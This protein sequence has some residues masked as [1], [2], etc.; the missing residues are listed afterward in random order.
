MFA[1]KIHEEAHKAFEKGDYSEAILGYSKALI[2][3]P[4]NSIVLS[5]RAIA[6]LHT[7]QKEKCIADFDLAVELQPKY[8]FR[9]A[10][11]AYAKKHFNDIDGAIE[12]YEK[13][14]DLDPSDEISQ[15]NLGVLLE[16]MGAQAQAN[17]HF[18]KSDEL[19]KKKENSLPT[20]KKEEQV[21]QEN[22]TKKNT[23]ETNKEERLTDEE[24]S[25]KME[26][27]KKIF[28]SKKQFNEFMQFLTRKFKVK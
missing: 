27:F 19:R 9:Y 22:Q 25:S 14:I 5:D 24:I 17:A 3:S 11:R 20:V 4:Q 28:T 12:D 26:E 6:Y 23:I 16:E 8:A 1:N 21:Q 2:E 10:S 7:N 18:E 15:N 13:A